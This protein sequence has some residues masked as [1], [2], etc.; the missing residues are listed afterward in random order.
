MRNGWVWPLP[1]CALSSMNPLP[2]HSL[3]RRKAVWGPKRIASA[4]LVT[5]ACWA[6]S[7]TFAKPHHREGARKQSGVRSARVKDYRI[8]EELSTRSNDRSRSTATTRVIVT[9]VPGG[10]LPTDVKRYL[11]RVGP[12]ETLDLINALVLDLPNGLVK[13]LAAS[14]AVARLQYD[15]PIATHNYRTAV[16]VGSRR[17]QEY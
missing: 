10:T 5:L 9:L 12:V 16:T 14:P 3:S 4:L 11:R 2:C 15:R 1:C 7:T 17:V 6:P 13:Q 8:D